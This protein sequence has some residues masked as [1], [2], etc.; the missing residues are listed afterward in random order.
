[1]NKLHSSWKVLQKEYK[2]IEIIGEG[3]EGI[4]IKAKNRVE[5]INC[6]IKR[7]SC[8][9]DDMH[10]MKYILREISIMR[11]LTQMDECSFAPMLIDIVIPGDSISKLKC[12]FLIMEYIPKT[13]KYALKDDEW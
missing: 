12:V 4:V 3:V 7:I 8:S 9:F 5:K 11:Q 1:M 13:L 6:A 2:L 10:Q